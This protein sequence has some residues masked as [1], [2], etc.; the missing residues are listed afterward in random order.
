[1]RATVARGKAQLIQLGLSITVFFADRLL[2][3]SRRL[4]S[5]S[6]LAAGDAAAGSSTRLQPSEDDD[7]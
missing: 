4:A 6:L 2:A 1:M 7:A 3:L 5:L